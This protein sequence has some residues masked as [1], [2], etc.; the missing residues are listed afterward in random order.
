MEYSS[1]WGL[2]IALGKILQFWAAIILHLELRL[3]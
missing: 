1:E 3:R 2:K